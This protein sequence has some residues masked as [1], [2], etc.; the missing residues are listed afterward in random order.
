MSTNARQNRVGWVAGIGLVACLV[1]TLPSRAVSLQPENT[2]SGYLARLLINEVPFPGERGW[3][4]EEDTRKAM[5]AVLWV[6]ESRLHHIPG[7]YTQEEVADRNTENVADI[8]TAGGIKGQCDGFYEGRGNMFLAAPRVHDR[9]RYLTKLAQKGTPGRF[10][11]LLDF[12]QG[13]ASAYVAGGIAEADVFAGLTAIGS[14]PVTGR[15]YG[16]MSD[17]D[18]HHPGGFFIRIPDELGG[19]LGGNRFYTLGKRYQ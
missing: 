15:A 12:A 11:R 4:S 18:C 1:W 17:Q 14:T 13:L 19:R 10:A 2:V 7:G 6:L 3:V 5:V 9:V 8:I 16:W